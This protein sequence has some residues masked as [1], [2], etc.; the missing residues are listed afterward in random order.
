MFVSLSLFCAVSQTIGYIRPYTN[1]PSVTKAYNR[2]ARNA[3]LF[4]WTSPEI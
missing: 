2:V 4:D 1:L 3:F